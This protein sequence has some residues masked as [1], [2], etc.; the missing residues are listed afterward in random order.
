MGEKTLE[1]LGFECRGEVTLDDT[2]GKSLRYVLFGTERMDLYDCFEEEICID[3]LLEHKRYWIENYTIPHESL[4]VFT[5]PEL[6]CAITNKMKDLG[7]I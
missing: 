3:F 6:H 5:E 1:D 4:P 7:W 2:L